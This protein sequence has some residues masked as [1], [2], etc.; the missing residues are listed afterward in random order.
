MIY[1]ICGPTGVG[2]TKL[3]VSLA[4]HFN[5]IVVNA[6]SMQ[7]YKNLNIGTAKVTEE[8]KEGVP[9]LLFDVVSPT[10]M[11]TIFDYQRDLRRV[12]DENKGKDIILVGGSG[13]YIKAGLYDYKFALEES[14]KTFDEYSNEELL[15]MVKKK[16]STSDI[17]VNNRKRLI[18]KL[19]QKEVSLDGDKL[20][21]DAKFIGLTTS[22]EKLYDRINKRVDKMM[23]NIT[24][25]DDVILSIDLNNGTI[26]PVNEN[27][28][29]TIYGR[30][31]IN[32]CYAICLELLSSIILF[33][34]III[35]LLRNILKTKNSFDYRLEK[36]LRKYDKNIVNVKS[37][38]RIDNKKIT[39]VSSFKELLNASKESKCPINYLDI[40]NHHEA[41]FIIMLSDLTY[42]YKLK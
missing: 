7:V 35:L 18:R 5:G 8:E 17:H 33:T 9:H 22:R 15:E 28:N 4:K 27:K 11:Y 6:D 10:E 20:L 34:L 36:I 26:N 19:N 40:K 2:K 29:E 16:D 3:S 21:F 24:K 42:V 41:T 38:P 14:H 31:D 12:I 30:I 39:F 23:E 13:L 1:V 32:T 37:F 25:N